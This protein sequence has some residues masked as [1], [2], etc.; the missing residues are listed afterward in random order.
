MHFPIIYLQLLQ[1]P[2]RDV[3]EGVARHHQR[4]QLVFPAR[5]DAVALAAVVGVGVVVVGVVAVHAAHVVRAQ[6]ADVCRR[7]WV[8]GRVRE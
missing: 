4:L 8:D 6:Q 5:A 7:M 3:Q 2:P 1:D